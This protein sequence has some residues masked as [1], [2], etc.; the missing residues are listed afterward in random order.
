MLRSLVCGVEV[1][2][3]ALTGTMRYALW[4]VPSTGGPYQTLAQQTS[5]NLAAAAEVMPV[6][7]HVTLCPSFVS[8]RKRAIQ[9]SKEVAKAIGEAVLLKPKGE[10]ETSL[11]AHFR[12]AMVEF[13]RSEEL[14]A[15]TRTARGILGHDVDDPGKG[16][17][18]FKPHMSVLYGMH[19]AET[20]QGAKAEIECSRLVEDRFDGVAVAL[21]MCSGID[22]QCWD[23]VARFP[24]G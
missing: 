12:A 15:A 20:L 14:L 3:A 1:A 18:R 19:T 17:A 2:T 23:E 8:G 21:V 24:L 6:T 7:P 16:I 5:D 13:E 9:L 4:L 22:H 10:A 11:D